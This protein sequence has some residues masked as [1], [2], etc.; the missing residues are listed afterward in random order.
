MGAEMTSSEHI[1]CALRHEEADRVAIQDSPWA[2]TVARW[3][4]EGLP[5]KV[6]SAEFFDYEFVRLGA[7]LSFRF[8]TKVLEETDEYRIHTDANGRTLKNWKGS[9]STPMLIDYKVK[10]RDDWE[11]HKHRLTADPSRINWDAM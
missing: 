2:T 5:E 11:R 8:P 7:D 1:T 10:T 4:R 3:R 9:T 6:S